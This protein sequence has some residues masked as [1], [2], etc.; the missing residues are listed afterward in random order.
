[1]VGG[2]QLTMVSTVLTVF[3]F[4]TLSVRV[5]GDV[6]FES[7]LGVVFLAGLA[8]PAVVVGVV[9]SG[10]ATSE[11]ALKVS[12]AAASEMAYV[13]FMVSMHSVF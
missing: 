1:M 2:V 7:F 13:S 8:T 12:A 11:Q 6:F 3:V 9:V 10:A 4:L 5:F